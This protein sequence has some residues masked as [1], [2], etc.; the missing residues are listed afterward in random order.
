M[1]KLYALL[2]FFIGLTTAQGQSV[3]SSSSNRLI[4]GTHQERTAAIGVS[5]IDKDAGEDIHIPNRNRQNEIS[6]N[7]DPA[8][9]NIE[10]TG[11]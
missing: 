5:D 6:L 2:L 7:D 9:Q 11:I 10:S 8:L 3:N 4:L 1:T